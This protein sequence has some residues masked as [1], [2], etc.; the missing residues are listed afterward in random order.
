MCPAIY[1]KTNHIFFLF[2][3]DFTIYFF[4]IYSG[5]KFETDILFLDR[6]TATFY[7]VCLRTIILLYS[8]SHIS[9]FL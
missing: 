2:L 7:A 6:V 3:T 4:R 5:C 8:A 1:V 9:L